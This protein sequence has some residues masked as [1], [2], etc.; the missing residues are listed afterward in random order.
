MFIRT[1][2]LFLRP[3]WPEDWRDIEAGITDLGV[4]R[5]LSS[6]P[7][8]Y[9][10]D[11]AREF[12]ARTQEHKAPHFLVTLPDNREAGVIGVTGLARRD[13]GIEL[14]YWFA[15]EHWGQ[16]YATEAARAVVGLARTLGH[17]RLNSGHYLDNP[18]SGRVL[19]K[20]GFRPT[21]EIDQHHNPARGVTVPVRRMAIDLT[22]SDDGGSDGEPDMPRLRAA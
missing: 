11:H 2:R 13:N 3:G 12:A 7:W 21:G 15:R 5:N 17:H 6:P 8:P 9:T 19:A 18:A 16:G 14:G 1:E 20:V 22:S 10:E 4:I